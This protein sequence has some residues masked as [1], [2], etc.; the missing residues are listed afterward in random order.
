MKREDGA[1]TRGGGRKAVSEQLDTVDGK[2][3]SR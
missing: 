2:T 1:E 3:R